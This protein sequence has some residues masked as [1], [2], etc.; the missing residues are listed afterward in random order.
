MGESEL[1]FRE[2]PSRQPLF[3]DSADLCESSN[4]SLCGASSSDSETS[5]FDFNGTSHQHPTV[6]RPFD[7]LL[8]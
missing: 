4:G 8:V 7:A 2:A 1:A 3:E 5:S 6:L